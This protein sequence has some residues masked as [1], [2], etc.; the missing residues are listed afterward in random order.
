MKLI[1]DEF[2]KLTGV[3][4]LWIIL[5]MLIAGNIVI[6]Y[7]T[8]VKTRPRGIET[9]QIAEFYEKYSADPDAMNAYYADMLEFNRQQ[10][11]L[12]IEAMREG[13]DYNPERWVNQYGTDEFGDRALFA[14]LFLSVDAP[15]QYSSDIRKVIRSAEAN[16]AELEY[17]GVPAGDYACRSQAE[18][19]RM[20]QYVREN[21]DIKFEYIRGWNDYFGY[22]TV[23]VFI[24]M[25]LILFASVIFTQERVNGFLPVLRASRRGRVTTALVKCGLMTLITIGTVLLFTG[26][27]FAVFGAVLGYSSPGNA[28]QAL[29]SYKYCPYLLTIGEYF[30]VTLALRLLTFVTFSGVILFI[31]VFAAQYLYVYAAGL[32]V[33]GVNF[34]LYSLVKINSNSLVRNLNFFAAAAVQPLFVRFR[35]FSLFSYPCSYVP[36][37]LCVFSALFIL[38]TAGTV[39]AF[40]LRKG[41]AVSSPRRLLSRLSIQ[42]LV[43][44]V[45][46]DRSASHTRSTSH[47]GAQRIRQR[48]LSLVGYENH[49]LL[50]ASRMIAV[51][52]AALCLRCVISYNGNVPPD[53]SFERIYRSYMT[54]LEGEITDEKREYI[55]KES[56]FISKTLAMQDTMYADYSG[57][58]IDYPTYS[59]YLA[60]Y[61]YAMSHS[62]AI[63]V[64]SEHAK[65]IDKCKAETGIDAWFV[66]DSGWLRLFGTD[67]DILLLAAVVVLLAGVFADEY[68]S[69]SSS[70]GFAQILRSTKRGRRQTFAAKLVAAVIIAAAMTLLFNTADALII[71]KRFF[72]PAQSAPVQSL[73]LFEGF[74]TGMTILEYTV[75]MYVIRLCAA[76]TLALLVCGLSCVLRRQLSVLSC[77]VALT[78]LPS[79]LAYFGLYV[80]RRV[81]FLRYFAGTPLCIDSI[82]ACGRLDV[83]AIFALA[84]A[85]LT[86]LTTAAATRRFC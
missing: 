29:S 32:G 49:K 80:M 1:S 22:D 61:N 2:R 62:E 54:E 65:Y 36:F 64:V 67:A 23:N 11:D 26:A 83:V 57:G 85:A 34:L 21:V 12:F 46:R 71:S 37:L 51:V 40:A 24:F 30:V 8:A 7:F 52:I 5:A 48:S 14:M 60:D 42:R 75:I 59:A 19:V 77:T 68:S 35:T 56:E 58:R 73:E 6:S 27:T 25:A 82:A 84:S 45:K 72:M 79:L 10:D 20:Y 33:A 66:Y 15:K 41:G 63:K 43:Q 18:C 76:V 38:G 9:S 70:G 78:L 39:T 53:D 86:A 13:K 74:A 31:S 47:G 4:Y 69:R 3:R 17:A 81:D 16:L 44:R 55:A 28:I 50:I